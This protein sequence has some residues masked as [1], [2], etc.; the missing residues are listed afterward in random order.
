MSAAFIYQ[1]V[2][3]MADPRGMHLGDG[4]YVVPDPYGHPD[5]IWIAVNDHRNMVVALDATAI[6]NM[7]AWLAVNRPQMLLYAVHGAERQ[8]ETAKRKLDEDFING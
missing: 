2:R 6:Y 7:L 1:R 4:A 3:D 8:T 5:Q